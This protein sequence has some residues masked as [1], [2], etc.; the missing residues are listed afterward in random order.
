MADDAFYTTRN[1]VVQ[2]FL[3]VSVIAAENQTLADSLFVNP[4]GI[5][6]LSAEVINSLYEIDNQTSGSW[7]IRWNQTVYPSDP[8][9][10][11]TR[12][13]IEFIAVEQ[14]PD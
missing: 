9:G 2:I 10:Q 7:Y 11:Q 4:A 6:D 5:E 12:A 14:S 8:N 13:N 3:P 1:I